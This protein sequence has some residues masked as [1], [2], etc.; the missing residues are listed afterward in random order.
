MNRWLLFGVSIG[1]LS[2]ALSP[3]SR[4]GYVIF[5]IM[6]LVMIVGFGIP[7]LRGARKASK[8]K[9]KDKEL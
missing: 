3:M 6:G 5:L 2:V 4:S 7:L 9:G 1:F 8:N